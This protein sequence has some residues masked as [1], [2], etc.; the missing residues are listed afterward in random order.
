MGSVLDELGTGEADCRR[1]VASRRM[2]AGVIRFLENA[3]VLKFRLSPF[4]II[5]F[6]LI[7]KIKNI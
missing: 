7:I 3:R 1:K 6:R 4:K 2:I 5:S